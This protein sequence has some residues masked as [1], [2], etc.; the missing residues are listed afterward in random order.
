[1]VSK[2]S[3]KFD[4]YLL[5][6][7]VFFIAVA[8]FSLKYTIDIISINDAVKTNANK[9]LIIDENAYNKLANPASYG[10]DVSTDGSSG[11]SDPFSAI[12]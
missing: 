6:F 5:I 3:K 11:K 1:M 9:S 7:G 4:F 2:I 12:K 10:A 8:V